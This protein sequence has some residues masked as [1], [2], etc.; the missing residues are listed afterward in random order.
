MWGNLPGWVISGIMLVATGWA[1]F[2]LEKM[3]VTTAATAMGRDQENLSRMQLPVS[4]ESVATFMT[5]PCDSG[6][7]YRQAIEAFKRDRTSIEAFVRQP[8]L[9]GIPSHPGLDLIRRGTNCQ[10]ARIFL[11][12]PDEVVNYD[13]RRTSLEALNAMGNALVLAGMLNRTANPAEA[14][15]N[16]EAAF[17][18]GYKLFEERLVYEQL[19]N[20][21]GLMGASST[22]LARIAEAEGNTQRAEDFQ[23]FEQSL[24]EFSQQRVMPM[25]TVI[26]SIDSR[27]IDR[28]AGDIFVFA[29]HG[30]E[31]V[32]QTE[33]ILKLGRYQYN[34]SRRADQEAAKRT[35]RDL[36]NHPD[37][38]L[39][40]AGRAARDLT[41]QQYRQLGW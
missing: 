7:F 39:S 30:Q 23:R 32:W 10:R 9:A 41:I 21:L 40:A 11:D 1:I 28:H 13:R 6:D 12:R 18:L 31:P 15:R 20:G 33:S 5:G 38:V 27:L 3:G 22:Y 8:S 26:S 25:W 19:S 24:K 29:L 34:A 16:L 36:A 14:K 4:P 35:V 17:S 2:S 37:P